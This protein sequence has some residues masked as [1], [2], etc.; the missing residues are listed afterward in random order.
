MPMANLTVK[1]KTNFEGFPK[2]A[3]VIEITGAYSL[4]AADRAIHNL[5]Y[6][7]AHDSGRLSDPDAEW[8]LTFAEIRRP[9]GKHQSN[10]QVR[11]SLKRL[12]KVQVTVHF[13][14]RDGLPR[15]LQTH[16]FD[17]FD[18]SDGGGS[19][20]TVQYG[21]P[22]KLQ[23]IL[24][25]SNR[26]G[27]VRCEVTYAMTSKYAIALY[28]L[29][30]LRL[31]LTR[32]TESFAIAQFRELLNVPPGAYTRADNFKAKVIDPALLE[33]NGLSDIGV[34]LELVRPRLRSPVSEVGVTWWRKEGDEYRAAIRE[35]H[36]H[37]AGR[38]ARLKGLVENIAAPSPVDT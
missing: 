11:E 29:I 20:A 36:R 23:P 28:E 5:L 2:A 37:K 1:Q 15:T 12:I 4:E 25:R 19:R 35:R 8:E 30:S 16:L 13:L 18:T 31:N 33:V 6:Q 38:T 7:H 27:R 14:G 3:E 10:D 9:L 24:A 34:A 32:T 26:W 21:I 17:F 22:K